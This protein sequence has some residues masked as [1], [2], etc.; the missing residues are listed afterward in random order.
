MEVTSS[1][2]ILETRQ[3][4]NFQPTISGVITIIC[5]YKLLVRFPATKMEPVTVLPIIPAHT[6]NVLPPEPIHNSRDGFEYRFEDYRKIDNIFNMSLRVCLLL[7]RFFLR[8]VCKTI[9]QL[10]KTCLVFD[11]YICYFNT[12]N[13][14]FNFF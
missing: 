8:N 3:K 13:F 14:F 4:Y 5:K 2:K 7:T 9:L 1:A 10:V 6:H 11:N 12:L